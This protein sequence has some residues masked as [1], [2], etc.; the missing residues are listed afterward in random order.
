ML[1][2]TR[3]QL[4]FARQEAMAAKALEQSLRQQLDDAAHKL[5]DAAHREADAALRYRELERDHAALRHSLDETRDTLRARDGDVMA[6]KGEAAAAKAAEAAARAAEV[7]AGREV[8]VLCAGYCVRDWFK[9]RGLL[10][11]AIV[12]PSTLPSMIVREGA[13]MPYCDAATVR[14]VSG[15]ADATWIGRPGEGPR[16]DC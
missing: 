4:S 6:V 11:G 1:Q 14:S 3:E 10:F 12:V 15:G 7:A 16:R 13:M 2:S 8:S 9:K 5:R